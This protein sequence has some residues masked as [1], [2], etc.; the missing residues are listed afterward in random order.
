M[1]AVKSYSKGK[2]SN[3]GA[4]SSSTSAIT[5]KV[6]DV[7]KKLSESHTL[8]GQEFN[9]TNDVS[10]DIKGVD[11][12]Y[13]SGDINTEGDVNADVVNANR[14]SVKE[15]I[16][17][18]ELN[19]KNL[20]A[21]TI[22]A[23]TT[24]TDKL[25]IGDEE[26]G[27]WII[28]EDNSVNLNIH[29]NQDKEFHVKPK[30]EDIFSVSS[31]K[32]KIN[33]KL[34][35]T[36]SNEGSKIV[37]GTAATDNKNNNVKSIVEEGIY[38]TDNNNNVAIGI[39]NNYVA[40]GADMGSPNFLSGSSGWRIQPDG[41][42]EFQNLKVDGNLD[43]YVLTYNEMRATNGIL[44]VT[45]CAC[46]TDA[47][48]QNIDEEYYW[49]I[50]VDEY[51]PFA[52]DDYVQLQYRA[53]ATRIFSFKGI[54]TAIN[55][56]G[57]NTI[58]VAP[59]S[60]FNGEGTS[61]DDRGVTTFKM[62]DPETASGQYIIRIGNKT[63][64]NRQTII[65]LNPYD[66]GYI[67][68]MTGLNAPDKLASNN[69]VQDSLPTAC[70]IGNLSGVAYKGTTLEGYGLFS[71][72][73]YL[74]G[75]IKHL[76]DKWS[77]NADGSGQIANKHIEWD[78]YGNLTI[79]LGDT[80]I[81]E[82]ISSQITISANSLVSD[83]TKKIADTKTELEGKI[84][85][86]KT[87]LE[88]KIT[89][90]A[91]ALT[92]DYTSMIE[93]TNGKITTAESNFT[94]TA[95]SISSRVKAIEDDYVTSSEISQTSEG[96]VARVKAI[97]DDYVTSSTLT[98]TA[99]GITSRVEAIENDYVTSS[100]LAQTSN[101]ITSRVKA[102]EDDYVTSSEI[103]QT[104]KNIKMSIYDEMNERT[105]INVLAGKIVIDADNTEFNGN[106]KLNN[107]DDG[108]TIFDSNSKPKVVIQNSVLPSNPDSQ[109]YTKRFDTSS[110][111]KL[112]Y[113]SEISS[114]NYVYTNTISKFSL[115][116]FTTSD[117]FSLNCGIS[118]RLAGFA[119]NSGVY[120]FPTNDNGN[121]TFNY[122]IFIVDPNNSSSTITIKEGSSS[123]GKV[124]NIVVNCTYNA[125]YFLYLYAYYVPLK[126]TI[127]SRKAYYNI[128]DYINI[129]L[130]CSSTGITVIGTNGIYSSNSTDSYMK[131]DIN[132]F[133]SKEG[134]Y[135]LRNSSTY[136][137]AYNPMGQTGTSWLT[138]ITCPHYNDIY[139][140]SF[141]N[142]QIYDSSG[143]QMTVKG[144]VPNVRFVNFLRVT[145]S[146]NDSSNEYW[147]VLPYAESTMI[148]I[149]NDSYDKDIRIYAEGVN[150]NSKN[151]YVNKSM[152]N[153]GSSRNV[154]D[155]Y[156]TLERRNNRTLILYATRYG[157]F[158]IN[159]I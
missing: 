102:I 78:E 119:E 136:G 93:D 53:D 158:N 77:L 83:Y 60:G 79:K 59:L 6:A 91:E 62:V 140:S 84:T 10:G 11:N 159:P 68:F 103:E 132:G 49:I 26:D 69:S 145:G 117:S 98:Q 46:I 143:S 147:V 130:S 16:E 156:Y 29:I 20:N 7:A 95:N 17:V 121:Y 19:T 99:N 2:D 1:I 38:F 104:G 57:D 31:S 139:S 24:N 40:L 25:C 97:E 111:E 44:L 50:T 51:P 73:V 88:G 14:I 64:T 55:Q 100:E 71:D 37:L 120:D 144:Y 134:N 85:T 5:L 43:V 67:D 94:Q 56:D 157:W 41:T 27:Q 146:F 15:G 48:D 58:R 86:T 96:I 129:T 76:E 4:T 34:D 21:E 124:N 112:T 39:T 138:P 133:I 33:K 155:H 137:L 150:N 70:R 52:I 122:K 35:L 18:E 63:D 23:G 128:G 142:Y 42:A 126:S 47:I 151:I 114:S 105:G 22:N 13:A 8:W 80:D 81:T 32:V 9:G 101:G 106:I 90:T 127:E 30:D 141:T 74:T 28:E 87:E 12:I 131:Y 89:Q 66:G 108:I 72:N 75:A 154:G 113:G 148:Y 61:T 152:G 125:E 109:K 107:P 110:Y 153:Y 135:L 149:R 116:T 54:V 36:N 115:G 45:D 118:I 82:Y 123:S 92:S 3:G 65:K